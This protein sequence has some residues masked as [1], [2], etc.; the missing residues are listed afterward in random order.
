MPRTFAHRCKNTL[1]EIKRDVFVKKIAHRVH[2]DHATAPPRSWQ[3]DNVF[4]QC[5]SEAVLIA[6][7]PHQLQSQCEALGITILAASAY[8]RATR[9]GIPRRLSPFDV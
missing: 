3:I 8:L 5:E 2:K 7:V 1:D 6:T 9:H 4:M